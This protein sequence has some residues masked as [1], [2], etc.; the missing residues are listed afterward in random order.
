MVTSEMVRSMAKDPIVFALANPD[1]EISYPEAK[2]ARPDVIMATGRSD[3]PNQVNNVL[4][5]PFIFRGA[6]DVRAKA[7][8]E[9]MK[10][11]AAR[12]LAALAKEDVPG[13]GLAAPTA[14]RSSASAASTSSRS[15]STRACC[16]GSRPAV[17][18]AAMDSRR[19][20][21]ERSTSTEYRERLRKMQSRA[22]QVMAPIFAKAREEARPHRL[23]RGPPPEDPAGGA[24]SCARR[25]SASRCSSGP[26]ETIQRSIARAAARATSKGVT[27]IDPM[28]SDATS[29]ATSRGYWRAAA[30]PAASRSRRRGAA[31]ACAQLLRAR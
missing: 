22:H 27:I 18:K 8:N 31:C 6:L 16:S 3:Y 11:A 1:P 19:R 24:R 13:R 10:M 15:R 30:A 14:A 17:A 2:E 23:P 20:P 25:R 12:A 7:I 9:E 28:T 4:G 5:F 26:V 29:A 21:P